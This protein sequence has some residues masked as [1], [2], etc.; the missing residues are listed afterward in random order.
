MK[1][2]VIVLGLATLFSC[3]KKVVVKKD[4]CN[5]DKI[6]KIESGDRYTNSNY[7]QS[8][9]KIFYTQN[10]C[11]GQK[12]MFEKKIDG[13]YLDKMQQIGDCFDLDS[14]Y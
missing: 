13:I 10:E 4:N 5:C 8:I 1:K 11:S 7:T 9:M 6:Y 2:L 12:L 14:R 3:E